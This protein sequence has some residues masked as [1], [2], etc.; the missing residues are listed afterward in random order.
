M[1]ILPAID[2]RGGAC[3]RLTQ[4]DYDRET[5]YFDDPVAVATKWAQE[6]AKI[7]HVVDLDG[8]KTGTPHIVE[9]IRNIAKS[10]H[11]PIQIGGGIR[12]AESAKALL[13]AGATRLII[14]TIAIEKPELLSDLV[15]L[16][17]DHIVVSLDA[18]QNEVVTRGW[19]RDTG[20]DLVTTAKS[21]IEVGVQ[22]IIYTDT[23]RDG[24]LTEPNY[25]VLEQLIKTT[26]SK[27][28]AAGGVA[29]VNHV[30]KLK[31]LGCSGVIIGK[32]LYEKTIS[33]PEALQA[34]C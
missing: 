10:T 34:T 16:F 25:K 19:L 3:V 8:A 27:I 6:G 9:V 22:R 31:S 2:I 15:K 11:L 1:E 24:T 33:L 32:A 13:N 29:T 20:R 17:A 26:K 7:L 21:L 23:V 14:G 30:K 4:G 12:S 5:K 28:I 18:K